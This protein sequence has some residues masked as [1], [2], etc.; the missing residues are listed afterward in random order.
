MGKTYKPGIYTAAQY[1]EEQYHQPDVMRVTKS[2]LDR[3]DVSGAHLKAQL[4]DPTIRQAT[5]AMRH[6]TAIH[7]AVLEP[8]KFTERYV[9]EL[10]PADYPLA[11]RTTDD[12]KEQ[13]R[14]YNDTVEAKEDKLKLTGSKKDLYDALH[15]VKPDLELFDNIVTS[16]G[17]EHAGKEFVTPDNWQ[18]YRDIYQAVKAHKGAATLLQKGKAEHSFICEDP[19][20]TQVDGNPLLLQ[21]R[22]DWYRP[23]RDIFVD[24]KTTE[25]ARP[26]QFYRSAIKYRYDVQAA[27]YSDVYQYTTGKPLKAF[28]FIAIEKS[29]PYACAVYAAGPRFIER[30]RSLYMENLSYYRT[31]LTNNL[32]PAYPDTIEPLELSDYDERKGIEAG[33][34][35]YK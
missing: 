18:T 11:L 16:Y 30:G 9:P 34:L 22:A 25:D 24:L 23:D 14:A 28:I 2:K 13:I 5:P 10:N 19:E 3:I 27:Y 26:Y 1:P 17:I 7:T 21:C 12:I 20:S 31:C 4:D 15:K 32:W 33:I 35:S 8:K 29:A 6:G